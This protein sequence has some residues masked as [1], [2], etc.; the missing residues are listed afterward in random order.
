M[1]PMLFRLVR[2]EIRISILISSERR[3]NTGSIPRGLPRGTFIFYFFAKMPV[4]LP[5]RLRLP[6]EWSF[7][8]FLFAAVASAAENYGWLHFY[9]YQYDELFVVVVVL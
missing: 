2:S 3:R 6:Q 1:L 7:P 9:Y 4:L 8:C 5:N